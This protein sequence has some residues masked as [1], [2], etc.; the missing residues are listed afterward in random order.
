MVSDVGLVGLVGVVSSSEHAIANS[1]G[2][3]KARRRSVLFSKCMGLK[4]GGE[5]RNI[6]I[7]VLIF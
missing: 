1:N 2:I 7:L 5:G 3:R 4:E 6:K